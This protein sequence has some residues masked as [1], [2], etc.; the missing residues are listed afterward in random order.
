MLTPT[1]LNTTIFQGNV[2]DIYRD[3]SAIIITE[4]GS[5]KRLYGF[6]QNVCDKWFSNFHRVIMN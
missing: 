6:G 4:E 3:L 2:I 5:T 1:F